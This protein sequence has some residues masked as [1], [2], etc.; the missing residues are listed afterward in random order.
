MTYLTAEAAG[1]RVYFVLCEC[2]V[3][4]CFPRL[5][6]HSATARLRCN[7]HSRS[8]GTPRVSEGTR[9]G[10]VRRRIPSVLDRGLPFAALSGRLEFPARIGGDLT[11]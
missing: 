11:V 8:V 6:E 1:R 4:G 2:S 3:F 9:R 5:Q 10:C 7:Q